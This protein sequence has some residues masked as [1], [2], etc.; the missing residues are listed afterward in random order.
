VAFRKGAGPA[1]AATDCEAQEN[2]SKEPF[3]KPSS[4]KTQ[5]RKGGRRSRDKGARAEREIVTRHIE[6]GIKAERYPLSGASRFRGQ[7]HDVDVY[8]FGADEAPAICEVKSRAAGGGFITIEKWLGEYDALF[9]RRDNADP[10]VCV[11]WRIWSRLIKR[12]RAS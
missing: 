7:G 3:S 5:A 4:P 11:P 2:I 12:G 8:L 10:L 1:S 9:L 6:L